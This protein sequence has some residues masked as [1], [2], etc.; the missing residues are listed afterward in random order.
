V[1]DAHP[2]ER[3]GDDRA[4]AAEP[5]HA[6]PESCQRR[7][8][9]V[10]PRG[11]GPR[12]L[13]PERRGGQNSRVKGRAETRADHLYDFA[14]APLPFAWAS[15]FPE[16]RAPAAVARRER[17]PDEWHARHRLDAR[18]APWLSADVVRAHPLPAGASGM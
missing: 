2:R 7:L 6:N 8:C 12:E 11:H 14:V 13:L 4:D 10:A 15:L 3:L 9:L 16:S 5:D 18:G 1:L 17:Q